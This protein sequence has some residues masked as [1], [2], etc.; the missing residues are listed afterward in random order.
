VVTD[1]D[2]LF[3]NT[4]GNAGMARGGSG[5][6]LTGMIAALISQV[7]EPKLLNAAVCGVYLHGLAGDIAAGIKTKTG[8]LPGDIPEALPLAMRKT[9]L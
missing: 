1:G 8:M 9:K 6:V 5:D 2:R 3:V 7:R 4:T